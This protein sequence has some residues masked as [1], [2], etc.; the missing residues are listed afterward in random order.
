[1]RRLP[2]PM[3]K[4]LGNYSYDAE[5]YLVKMLKPGIAISELYDSTHKFLLS[6]SSS[7]KDKLPNNFGFGVL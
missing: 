2:T 6:K 5:K 1:M 7:Y 4:S 3:C